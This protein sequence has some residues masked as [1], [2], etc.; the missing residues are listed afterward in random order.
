[1]NVGVSSVELP[2]PPTAEPRGLLSVVLNHILANILVPLFYAFL[3]I[4]IGKSK[5]RVEEED[6]EDMKELAAWAS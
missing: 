6:D 2:S 3:H 4:R 5:V 1:M